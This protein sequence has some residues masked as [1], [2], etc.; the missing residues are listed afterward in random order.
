[1]DEGRRIQA[2]VNARIIAKIPAHAA[3]SIVAIVVATPPSLHV[4]GTG[5]LFEL[6]RE[7]SV[8]TAGH[9]IKTASAYGKTIGISDDARSFI[10][11]AGE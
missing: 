2:H 1:V 4:F 3:E 5:N 6:A 11:T 9:V 8:V 7:S 10:A